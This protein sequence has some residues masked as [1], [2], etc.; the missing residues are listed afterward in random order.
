MVC[1]PYWAKQTFPN[2]TGGK[3]WGRGESGHFWH[4]SHWPSDPASRNLSQICTGKNRKSC[5]R[6]VLHR[7]IL[8][9]AKDWKR[10]RGQSIG[11]QENKPQGS[12]PAKC[13]GAVE[14]S[15][16]DFHALDGGI[17]GFYC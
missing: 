14:R 6:V 12:P 2:T 1:C 11:F 5:L 7:G 3:P 10:A 9:V 15:V 16:N 8:L 17:P 4:F 13:L